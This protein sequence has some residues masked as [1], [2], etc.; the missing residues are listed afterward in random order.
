MPA[1]RALL[2]ELG[3]LLRE[4]VGVDLVGQLGD[5]EALPVVDL[6]DLHD[7]PHD[8]RAAPGAVGVLDAAAA[9]D[10]R[11]GREVRALDALHQRLEQLLAWRLRVLEVPLGAGGDLTQVVRRDVGG[12]ADRDAGGAVDQQVGEAAR[13]DRGLLRLAVVVV[14]EVDRVLVDVTHHLQRQRRHPA[15]GVPRRGGRVVARAAEVALAVDERVAHRPVLHEAHER[16]V[17]RGVAVRVVLAHDLADDARALVV[18]AVGPVAAVVHGVHDAPV[19]RLEPVTH[20]WQRAADDDRHRVVDVAALH[21]GVEI[22]RLGA[23]RLDGRHS[24]SHAIPLSV[25]GFQALGVCRGLS[26]T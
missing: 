5:D 1:R 12:H 20:V 21:L 25:N 15:L 9:Q 14:A 18:P 13:Q 3:D 23:V 6:L 16:V 11:A 7:R 2:D 17:D 24:V 4:G 10:Q 22:D 8:D 26:S 19:H